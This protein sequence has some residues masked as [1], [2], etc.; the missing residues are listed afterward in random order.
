MH[1]HVDEDRCVSSGQCAIAAP[2]LFDQHEDT[3]IAWLRTDH[4]TPDQE[5]GAHDAASVCPVMAIT[6]AK[7]RT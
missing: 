4:P 1:V 2:E 5:K 3:G 7:D 6:V